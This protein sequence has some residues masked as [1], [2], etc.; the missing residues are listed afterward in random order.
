MVLRTK[1]S[2][3]LS[4]KPQDKEKNESS[5]YKSILSFV[6]KSKDFRNAETNI[7]VTSEIYDVYSSC[8]S[9]PVSLTQEYRLIFCHP[10]NNNDLSWCIKTDNTNETDNIIEI[11]FSQVPHKEFSK[12]KEFSQYEEK[13]KLVNQGHTAIQINEWNIN[14]IL[15]EFKNNPELFKKLLDWL[16]DDTN[17]KDERI[18]TIIKACYLPLPIDDLYFQRYNNHAIVITNAKTGKTHTYSNISGKV[19]SVDYS[20]A[21]LIGT[22]S[23][24]G[25]NKGSLSGTGFFGFDEI[26]GLKDKESTS[27]GIANRLLNYMEDGVSIRDL[28]TKIECRG[29][30]S[31]IF[32][33]NTTGIISENSMNKTMTL[34]VNSLDTEKLGRRLAHIIFNDEIKICK[35]KKLTR[36]DLKAK[37]IIKNIIT[38]IV[39]DAKDKIIDE[40]ERMSNF[41]EQDIEGEDIEYHSI[42]D[43]LSDSLQTS[44][45]K[46]LIKGIKMSTSRL[47][48][49]SA[50]I[51]LLNNLDKIVLSKDKIDISV[52]SDELRYYY[53]K[54]K[55]WNIETFE[56][57]LK[58]NIGFDK[59]VEDIERLDID[60]DVLFAPLTPVKRDELASKLNIDI[61]SL[62]R[63]KIKFER[64][65]HNKHTRA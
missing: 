43:S 21:G 55:E 64:M 54:F 39:K 3:F 59:F 1:E 35:N 25:I 6:K 14:K 49:A 23:Q 56:N 20:E 34:F 31:L 19:P 15:E 36:K 5:N 28:A 51:V 7:M 57:L 48:F 32:F 11:A 62:Y 29:T 17:S 60:T 40:L 50:K 52:F 10:P 53:K 4:I 16:I 2:N 38:E 44:S 42:L 65:H 24:H 58:E 47:H 22:N 13:L 37:K 33:G 27:S 30:K 61:S 18:T 12:Y 41:L 8:S 46:R 45:M 63:Y 9:S 26:T